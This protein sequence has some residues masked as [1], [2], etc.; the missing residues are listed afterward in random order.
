MFF[1]FS[2]AAL[3]SLHLQLN[4]HTALAAGAHVLNDVSALRHDPRSLEFA[5]SSGKPVIL[6]HAPG[7]GD[8]LHA[9]GSYQAVVF[10]VFD[11][12]RERPSSIGI[13]PRTYKMFALKPD[14]PTRA[15]RMLYLP[16]LM[17]LVSIIGL[18]TG[19]W[20]IRRK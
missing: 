9:N 8:D 3:P 16:L 15:G 14:A 1:A 11:W 5:A 19:I 6:M 12:L 18:G 20:V 2:V 13:E 4:H 10:D 17:A 7:D